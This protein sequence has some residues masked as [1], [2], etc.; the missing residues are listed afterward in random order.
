MTERQETRYRRLETAL[1]TPTGRGA[2]ACVGVR[3]E[4]AWALFRRRWSRADGK[5]VPEEFDRWSPDHARRPFFGLFR[6]DELGGAADEIVLRRRT[7]DAF[8]IDGHG[9]D[10]ASSRVVKYFVE[11]GAT[12]VSGDEWER[13]VELEEL[14][15]TEREF[16]ARW[17]SRVDSLFYAA[18]DAL[19]TR[20]TTERIA[21]IAVRQ[22]GLFR[23]FFA[24]LDALL[25]Q[26]APDFDACVAKLDAALARGT[27]GRKLVEP[28]TVA[29]LGAP[30]VGKS[31]LLNAALGFER[32]VTSPTPGTTRDLVGAPT[33]I[34]GWNFR[35]VDAAGLRATDDPLERMGAELA[36]R[37]ALTA[38]VAL[39]VYDASRSRAEQDAEFMRFFGKPGL[40]VGRRTVAALNKID[41][42]ESERDPSWSAPDVDSAFLRVSARTRVGLDE[43]ASAL[44]AA[45]FDAPVDG[46]EPALWTSEQVEFLRELRELCACRK[47]ASARDAIRV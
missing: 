41:L 29:F 17:N 5:P 2:V 28:I 45:A 40:E 39:A 26:D 32:V 16:D 3:G 18:A 10:A 24:G 22:R 9:G 37:N 31:S 47:G 20:A 19:A 38:D 46:S 25:A 11:H 43:L 12:L 1:L 36:A 8:E 44:A 7:A 15:L 33:V 14:G 35:L 23:A 6:F 13:A 27:C 4:G 30:N 42:P 34:D 21:R